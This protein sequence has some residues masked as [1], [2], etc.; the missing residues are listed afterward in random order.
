MHISFKDVDSNR[1]SPFRFGIRC[2]ICSVRLMSKKQFEGLRIRNVDVSDGFYHCDS[3]KF[4][5]CSNCFALIKSFCQS[6]KF[7]EEENSIVLM[8]YDD[9]D[10]SSCSC[11]RCKKTERTQFELRCQ[12]CGRVMCSNCFRNTAVCSLQMF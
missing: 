8:R 9:S 10:S 3:C 7:C 11:D 1:R 12:K 4:D 2:D 6:C 5:L